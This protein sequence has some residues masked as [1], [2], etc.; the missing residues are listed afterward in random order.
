MNNFSKNLSTAPNF[1]M[2]S[3]NL[4]NFPTERNN[5]LLSSV[6]NK[7]PKVSTLS[8]FVTLRDQMF[9]EVYKLQRIS[10]LKH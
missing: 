4:H 6:Y 5:R 8:T 9:G 2:I 10:L 3:L 7:R 1:V